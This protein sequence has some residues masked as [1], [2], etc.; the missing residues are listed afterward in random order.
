M[1]EGGSW[2][3]REP[4]APFVPPVPWLKSASVSKFTHFST[5][6]CAHR[7]AKSLA[8]SACANCAA[9]PNSTDRLRA[10]TQLVKNLFT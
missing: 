1:P 4:H 5:P 7:V 10:R 3:N 8:A 9:V 6:V 2:P